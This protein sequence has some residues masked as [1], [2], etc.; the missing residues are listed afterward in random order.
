MIDRDFGLIVAIAGV[1][2]IVI[3][4]AL[5]EMLWGDSDVVGVIVACIGFFSA[6]GGWLSRS[7]KPKAT[8]KEIPPEV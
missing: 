4:G 3:L 2:S 6:V 1:V 7:A 5:G 8:K